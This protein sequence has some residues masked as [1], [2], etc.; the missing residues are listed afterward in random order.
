MQNLL[1]DACQTLIQIKDCPSL[2]VRDLQQYGA[3]DAMNM[4]FR[5]CPFSTLPL[6]CA[7]SSKAQLIT[8]L[9]VEAVLFEHRMMLL[10]RSNF[11]PMAKWTC[12]PCGWWKEGAC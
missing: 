3:N 2:S 10:T 11:D 8:L 12:G 9:Q 4:W 1:D 6:L 7:P 5:C